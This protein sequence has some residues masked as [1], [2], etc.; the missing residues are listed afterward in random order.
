LTGPEARAGGAAD[1]RAPR[2]DTGS[3]TPDCE[4]RAGDDAAT[5]ALRELLIDG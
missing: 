3:P 5:T 1:H 4:F 2:T